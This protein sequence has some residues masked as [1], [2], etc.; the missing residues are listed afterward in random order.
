MFLGKIIMPHEIIRL[1]Y[2]ATGGNQDGG[3]FEVRAIFRISASGWNEVKTILTSKRRFFPPYF[4][5]RSLWV[6][7]LAA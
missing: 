4:P 7:C 3:A 1:N 6:L 2:S 5:L